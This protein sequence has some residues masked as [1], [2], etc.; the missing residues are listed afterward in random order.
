MIKTLTNKSDPWDDLVEHSRILIRVDV[1]VNRSSSDQKKKK[2]K[3]SDDNKGIYKNIFHKVGNNTGVS[4][5]T[6]HEVNKQYC[7]KAK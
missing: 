4:L 6:I 1:S 5:N 2:K 3:K 7:I